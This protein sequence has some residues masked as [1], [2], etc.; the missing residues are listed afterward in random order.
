M[1]QT[2]GRLG[3]F[4]LVVILSALATGC[5]TNKDMSVMQGSV[6]AQFAEIKALS[7]KALRISQGASEAA[8]SAVKTSKEANATSQAAASSAQSAVT[9]AQEAVATANNSDTT[10]K[11]AAQRADEANTTAD[12][13]VGTS[14][15]ALTN[16]QA[17]VGTSKDA[18]AV[19][20]SQKAVL[21]A[22]LVASKR[23][24]VASYDSASMAAGARQAAA[25]LRG[26]MDETIVI[27]NEAKSLVYEMKA[28][29]MNKEIAR[30][31]ADAEMAK[32]ANQ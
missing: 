9:T 19:L 15:D 3:G 31:K 18:L 16:S 6:E 32:A 8:D 4:S 5:A 14:K 27:S 12:A 11:T 13:A 23:A 30:E 2:L 17:A 25:A 22:A 21:D 1:K 28:E 29:M 10:S 20:E 24:E 7:E 26:K